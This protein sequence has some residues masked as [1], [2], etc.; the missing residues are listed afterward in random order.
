M[1]ELLLT[2]LFNLIVVNYLCFSYVTITVYGFIILTFW[3]LAEH[4][5]FTLHE[6]SSLDLHTHKKANVKK[7]EIFMNK[8]NGEMDIKIQG[9]SL[10]NHFLISQLQH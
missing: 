10:N 5:I 1:T 4:L 6:L 2:S 8:I 9:I 3:A 7:W